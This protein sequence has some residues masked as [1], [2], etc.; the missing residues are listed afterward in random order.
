[1]HGRAEYKQTIERLR[2]AFPDLTLTVEDN[3]AEGDKVVSRVIFRGTHE[4]DF[5]GFDPT[6]RS[7]QFETIVINRFEN[8]ELA[9]AW[10]QADVLGVMQQLGIVEGPGSEGA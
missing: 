10:V 8:E 5:Q 1:M 7:V 3:I 6:G 2:T 4:G 9:E